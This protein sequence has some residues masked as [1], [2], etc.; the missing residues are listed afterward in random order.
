LG[1]A[2]ATKKA[3]KEKAKSQRMSGLALG[4]VVVS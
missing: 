1:N 4:W 3:A 2:L